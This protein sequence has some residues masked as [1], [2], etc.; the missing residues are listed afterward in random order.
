[1]IP[2]IFD[3]SNN[4]VI[5]SDTI[6][7]IPI[8]RNFHEQYQDDALNMFSVIWFYFDLES[9]YINVE[10]D[11]KL[12][13]ILNELG[14]KE[15][16]YLLNPDFCEIFDWCNDKYVTTGER[17]W[18]NH[19]R[20]IENIG[21]WAATPVSGGREGDAAQ[22]ISAAKEAKRLYTELVAFEQEI[23]KNLKVYGDEEIA[24][25]QKL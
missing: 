21:T 16:D 18:R 17:F 14:F 1:M 6:L 15:K 20:N 2:K 5:V 11:N 24:F 7:R 8:L 22:K 10:E 23:T 9:P 3:I 4:K 19:K 13:F 12:E 25:D